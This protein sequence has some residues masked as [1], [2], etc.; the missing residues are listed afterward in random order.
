MPPPLNVSPAKPSFGLSVNECVTAKV[1]V[2]CC[3][4]QVAITS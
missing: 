1:A 3:L 2:T 4:H